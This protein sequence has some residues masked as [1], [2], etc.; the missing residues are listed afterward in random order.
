MKSSYICCVLLFVLFLVSCTDGRSEGQVARLLRQAE[1]CMEEYP[2]SALV[3]LHQI[4]DPEKLTGENQADYCLLLTQAMD[5]NDLPLSSDSLIQIAVGYYSNKGDAECKAKALFYKGRVFQQ[6][7]NLEGATLLYKKAES[8]ISDLTDYYLVGL[9]YSYLGHLNRDEEH[10]KKALFYYEKALPCYRTIQNPTLTASGLQ[11]MA[12][13]SVYLGETHRADSLFSEVLSYVPDIDAAWQANIYHNVGVFYMLTNQFGKAEQVVNTSLKLPSTPE[14]KLRSYAVLATI[15]TKQNRGDLVDSLWHKALNSENI[16]TRKAVYASLLNE[17]VSKQNLQDIEHYV[18]LYIQSADSVYQLSQAKRI[19][20]V[21]AKYDQEILIKKNKI[22]RLLLYCFILCLLLLAISL[23]YVFHVYKRYKR[24]KERELITQRAEL[25]EGKQV[26]KEMND[27]IE[28]IRKEASTMKEDYNKS[29]IDLTDEKKSI[30]Q[31]FALIKQR[32]DDV[33]QTNNKMEQDLLVLQEQLRK[34]D[35]AR[36]ELLAEL[37]VYRY[38]DAE[39]VISEDCYKA[40][41]TIYKLYNAPLVAFLR[42]PHLKL[43]PY[44]SLLCVLSYEHLSTQQMEQKLGKSKNT[45]NKAIFRIREKLDAKMDLKKNINS[46][47]D[48]LRTKF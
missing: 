24:T 12:K 8:M 20:E 21:Q 35:D 5:K 29:L 44:E 43:T 23:A 39:G 40:V 11:D 28:R 19:V 34:V 6:Q 16:Y 17:A 41:V 46:L 9:I 30:E 2:D 15:Y 36:S 48:F 18:P 13:I 10:Y 25:D 31:Q 14:D 27:Q 33:S 1:M 47:G 26:I 37:D 32:A 42:D 3:Y 4:P 45:L 7:G 38:F 22:S